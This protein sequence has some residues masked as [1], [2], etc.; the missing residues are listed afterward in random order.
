[1]LCL[2]FTLAAHGAEHS[3]E[4]TI[5]ATTDLRLASRLDAVLHAL[6]DRG[7]V[8]AARVV[9]LST[10]RELYTHNPDRPMMP[11]SNGKLANDAAGLDHFGPTH[12]FKTYLA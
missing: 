12:T 3:A 4:P 8:L 11:A 6:D 7:A 9:E 1:M 5:P 10:G 2:C